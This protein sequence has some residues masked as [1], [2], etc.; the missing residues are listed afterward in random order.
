[1]V[2]HSARDMRLHGAA[3]FAIRVPFATRGRFVPRDGKSEK[4]RQ[5]RSARFPPMRTSMRLRPSAGAPK[6][7]RNDF[8]YG[9]MEIIGG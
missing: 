2:K 4:E 5:G 3:P 9:D 6:K 7:R 1:M 8:F